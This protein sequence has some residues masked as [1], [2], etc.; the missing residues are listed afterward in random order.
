MNLKGKTVYRKA[1]V[2]AVKGADQRVS[3]DVSLSSETPVERFWGSEILVH[4]DSA[5]NMERAEYGL[6]FLINHDANRLIGRINNFRLEDGKTR[7]VLNFDDEDP[8]ARLWK[9]KFDRSV[10]RDFSIRYEIQDFEEI[11]RK[12][13]ETEF[14]I[15]SWTPV[16]GSIVGVAAD[17]NVGAGRSKPEDYIM[18]ENRVAADANGE[19]N[20]GSTQNTVV[21]FRAEHQSAYDS[22]AAEGERRA[23]AR[24]ADLEQDFSSLAPQYRSNPVF[25]AMRQRCIADGSTVDQFRAN[26][27]GLINTDPAEPVSVP[28]RLDPVSRP[29][30]A[31]ED[32]M[33]KWARGVDEALSYRCG[34][35]K[36]QDVERA[37]R[38]NPFSGLRLVEIGREYL[39][40]RGVS[41][42]AMNPS[43]VALACLTHQGVLPPM[44]ARGAVISHS[45][46]DF[47]NVLANI[48]WKMVGVGYQQA[49]ETW[50]SIVRIGA[51]MT[52][53][54]EGKIV[55][56][57]AFSALDEIP[58]TGEYKMGTIG[59]VGEPIMI[60]KF[61]KL[62]LFS[63]GAILND[64]MSVF[65]DIPRLIG[66]A[67]AAKVGD[68]VWTDVVVGNPTLTQNSNA[69]FSSGNNN[70]AASGAAPSVTTLD[71]A[72]AKMARQTISAASPDD[73]TATRTLNVEPR[74]I[75][76]PPELAG[77]A[78]VLTTALQQS[79]A[80]GATSGSQAQQ[81]QNRFTQLMPVSEA[82]LT[83]TTAWYLFADP[84][85]SLV[86]TIIVQFLNGQETPFM[87]QEPGFEQ[88]GIK[89]KIRLEAAAKPAAYQGVYKN[90]GV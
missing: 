67:A 30:T 79:I 90:P 10:A 59:D 25:Q 6:P 40:A 8:D 7:G 54:K 41:A 26:I 35:A 48:A 52:D 12:G 21:D 38:T 46:S 72:Y 68:L 69:L 51:G 50:R 70:L 87:E 19:N 13:Q 56:L 34:L 80:P 61:G 55:N 18:P 60:R 57:T 28:A 86:D 15:I 84:N 32:G 77:T 78:Q 76:T 53:Y 39:R 43:D 5:I 63:R 47:T 85:A 17:A 16:E 31:G 45:A 1:Q 83:S 64:D 29:A 89:Y 37:M 3:Y 73:P 33:E 65:T 44:A 4:S 9:S 71:A 74:I 20:G 62:L 82:R 88:D 36:T 42:G 66:G 22:G 14:R 24:I 81:G 49:N 11:E 75:A 23:A 27:L 58:D 2:V